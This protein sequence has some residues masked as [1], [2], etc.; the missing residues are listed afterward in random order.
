MDFSPVETPAVTMQKN[1][2][3]IRTLE[4]IK[5]SPPFQ[6]EREN[7]YKTLKIKK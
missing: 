3:G 7:I 4:M 2:T 1:T 6:N 5:K